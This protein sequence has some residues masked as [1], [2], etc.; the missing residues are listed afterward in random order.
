MQQRY[1]CM[2]I[3]KSNE[4]GNI[5]GWLPGLRGNLHNEVFRRSQKETV[6]EVLTSKQTGQSDFD[7]FSMH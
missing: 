1:R 5:E 2:H 6:S 4:H 7:T 3:L